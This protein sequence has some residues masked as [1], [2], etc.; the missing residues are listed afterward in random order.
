[1][2]SQLINSAILNYA[3]TKIWLLYEK[4][5]WTAIIRSRARKFSSTRGGRVVH[6]GILLID[7]T[8]S[9]TIYRLKSFA[10]NQATWVSIATQITWAVACQLRVSISNVVRWRCGPCVCGR[11]YKTNRRDRRR[12]N[13]VLQ[14]I[15]QKSHVLGQ[16]IGNVTPREVSDF[17]A[18][19]KRR[20]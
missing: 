8:V 16:Y 19:E 17:S 11:S 13:D 12:C 6:S 14:M 3:T 1:M 5:R 15:E 9:Y 7:P 2:L 18:K 4:R 10:E 20:R